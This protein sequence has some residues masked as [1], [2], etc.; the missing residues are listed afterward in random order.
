M[1]E[2]EL[3]I[4]GVCKPGRNKPNANAMEMIQASLRIWNVQG[5]LVFPTS[6]PSLPH[7][8]RNGYRRVAFSL[9]F[10]YLYYLS[11]FIS[12]HSSIQNYLL[13]NMSGTMLREYHRKQNK[14]QLKEL[15]YLQQRQ[16]RT[17]N[18][19]IIFFFFV[20]FWLL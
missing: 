7:N 6:S 10:W 14:P 2:S 1:I 19:I 20:N 3:P 4:S 9:L 18:Y 16:T 12:I 15:T 5:L 8:M 13:L 17:N 11:V